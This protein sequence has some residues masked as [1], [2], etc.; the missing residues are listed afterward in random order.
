[1]RR[2]GATLLGIIFGLLMGTGLGL[3]LIQAGLLNP[4]TKY[5][6]VFPI[7]GVIIGFL[8]G[9]V[10]GRRPRPVPPPAS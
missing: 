6:L 2:I 8:V 3:L 1:M 10:G 4:L 7:G 9:A 5:G